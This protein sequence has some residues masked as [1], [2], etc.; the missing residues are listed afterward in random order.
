MI[1]YKFVRVGRRTYGECVFV[2]IRSIWRKGG[3]KRSNERERPVDRLGAVMER[4]SEIAIEQELNRNRSY[5]RGRWER[6][7]RVLESVLLYFSCSRA[8]AA[9]RD[10]RKISKIGRAFYFL[11]AGFRISIPYIHHHSRK[12]HAITC[13]HPTSLAF[14]INSVK[15]KLFNWTL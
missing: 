11:V 4:G 8:R 5:I 13:P 12:L 10:G 6:E 7:W 9:A 2:S 3:E 1:I 15:P 14:Y